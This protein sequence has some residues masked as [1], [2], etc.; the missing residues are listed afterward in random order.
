MHAG[1]GTPICSLKYV[2]Q[3]DWCTYNAYVKDDGSCQECYQAIIG[4][5]EQGND[6]NNYLDDDAL[7]YLADHYGRLGCQ[8]P[9]RISWTGGVIC[10]TSA[11]L[12][13]VSTKVGMHLLCSLVQLPQQWSML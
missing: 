1:N 7:K 11:S 6:F 4:D 9:Y 2:N 13:V 3:H 8:Q 12:L 10:V 5:S